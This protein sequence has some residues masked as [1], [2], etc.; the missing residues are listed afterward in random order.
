MFSKAGFLEVGENQNFVIKDY[1]L[2]YQLCTT[3][4]DMIHCLFLVTNPMVEG[5]KSEK[6]VEGEVEMIPDRSMSEATST[7]KS[8]KTSDKHGENQPSI[9][10]S[11]A[12]QDEN[13]KDDDDDKDFYECSICS[14]CFNNK[15]AF[16]EHREEHT[17]MDFHCIYCGKRFKTTESLKVH[18]V[19]HDD[20]Q[21]VI[22]KCPY[23]SCKKSFLK[24]SLYEEHVSSHIGMY[25]CFKCGR[26]FRGRHNKD[27]HVRMCT[28]SG[29]FRC[30]FCNQGYSN[31]QALKRHKD[32]QHFLKK[33]VC[34]CGMS[35]R[36]QSSLVKHQRK[37]LH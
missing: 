24:R 13:M 12:I 2:P 6:D 19:L 18:M 28:D 37:N 17:E 31:A 9:F 29:N 27:M 35:Y 11:D 3:C 8:W 21:T 14:C 15:R 7:N 1:R 23:D 20:D 26:M 5:K 33:H 36:Y 30:E 16:D 34:S 4:E 10:D 32:A 22:L 25:T